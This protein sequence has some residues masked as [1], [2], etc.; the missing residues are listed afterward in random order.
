MSFVKNKMKKILIMS[1]GFLL[2]LLI[3]S[4]TFFVLESL[5]SSQPF[6]HDE[7]VYLT[8]ARSWIDGSPADQ[9]VIYRPIGMVTSGWILLHFDDSEQGVRTF[10]VIFGAVTILFTYLFFKRMFNTWVALCV[11]GV[12]EASFLFLREAPQFFNDI[13][14][15]GLLIGVLLLLYI[16][17][18]SAGKSK[19]IYFVGPLAALSFYLRY[20]TASALVIIGLVTLLVLVPKFVKKEGVDYSKLRTSFVISILLFVPHFLQ[21]LISMNDLLG[22]LNLSG[23]AA[24][25]QYFGEGLLDYL[26]WLPN[27][28]GGWALGITAIIGAIVVV[29]IIFRKNLRENYTSLLWIGSIGLLNFIVTGLLVHAEARYVFFPTVLLSGAG[30]AGVYCLVK[31]WSKIFANLLTIIFLLPV[32]YYGVSNYREIDSFLKKREIVPSS[33]AYNNAL[34]AI[35]DDSYDKGGCALWTVLYHPTSSWYSK[36]NLLKII[37]AATFEKDF[38]LHLNKAHYSIVYT[39]LK[40]VQISQEEASNFDVILTEIFRVKNLPLGDLVVYR[41]IRKNSAEEDYLNLLEMQ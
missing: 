18:E 19:A 31:N 11:V 14:S 28:L 3:F 20:G 10:G 41:I 16:Y 25:R 26:K 8:K 39:N 6:G 38:R 29:I 36:C 17:Y 9:F 40:K 12:V 21:S 15:S 33:I 24:G 13:P 34:K 32:L 37:D 30:I 23:K 22:I 7:S 5:V 35:R 27:D 1:P 2:G 4:G